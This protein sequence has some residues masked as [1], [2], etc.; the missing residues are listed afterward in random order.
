MGR[1]EMLAW[2]RSRVLEIVWAFLVPGASVAVL[3]YGGARVIDGNLTIG[4]VMMFSTYV[5]MLLSPIETLTAT[6]TT[7]QNNLAALDRVLDLLDEPRELSEHT[8]ERPLLKLK[9]ANARGLVEFRDVSFSYPSL[10]GSGI[11]VPASAP[12][13]LVLEGVCL[14]AHPGQTI[15]LVGASGAGKTTLSN[16]VARFYDPTGGQVLFDGT[17]LRDIEPASYRS[18]LG[19]VEQDVFLFDGSIGANIAYGRRH[20][21]PAEIKTAAERA[22]AHEFIAGMEDGYD[23]II[24]E[25]GVRLSG[26]QRQR[27]AIARAILADPVVLILDEATSNLD[28]ENE[29]LIRESLGVLMKGRTCFVIA[30]RLSTIRSADRIIVI[31]SGRIREEG[32]H[33]ELI[34]AGGKYAQLL[35]RQIDPSTVPA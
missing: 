34:H 14:A 28:A 3:L 20:A 7:V 5:L 13:R 16:L 23:T 33:D 2:C 19:I 8:T 22:H 18:L 27:L 26:G 30:H 25:R 10:S 1:Q 29:A 11:R 12:G 4:D 6:A 9:R 15:A 32:T 21:T 35:R 17:D 31:D 24:G